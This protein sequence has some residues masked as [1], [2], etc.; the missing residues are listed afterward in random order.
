[1][2]TLHAGQTTVFTLP[3]LVEASPC[4]LG[5]AFEVGSGVHLV[6]SPF[7]VAGEG[8]YAVA[9]EFAA[10]LMCVG[11]RRSPLLWCWPCLG[12]VRCL[13]SPIVMGKCVM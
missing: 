6:G 12:G 11:G 8:C 9:V 10:G 2:A 13:P 5:D 4:R 3:M 7:K 1:M